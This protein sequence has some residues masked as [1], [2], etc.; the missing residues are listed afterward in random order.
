VGGPKPFIQWVPFF[1]R[2][3]A[4]GHEDEHSSSSIAEFKKKWGYNSSPPI[5]LHDVD[6]D[7]FTFIFTFTFTLLAEKSACKVGMTTLLAD[8]NGNDYEWNCGSELRCN[9][10]K[11]S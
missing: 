8:Q 3:Q 7:N 5:R 9:A 4:A 10:L 11:K 6:R 1:S 2:N